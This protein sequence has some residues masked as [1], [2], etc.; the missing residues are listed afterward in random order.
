MW[1]TNMRAKKLLS[2]VLAF[3]MVLSLLPVSALAANYSDAEGHWAEAAINRWSDYGIVTGDE[4]GFRPNDNMT[5]AEAAKV[6]CELFGLT[7][8]AGAASFTDVPADAWYANYIAK[9]NAAGIMGGVGD[10]Q[11]NPNGTL[12][13]ETFF[14]MFARGLGLKEQSATSGVAA[15]G[16][17][18]ANGYINALTD[19]GYVKGDGT[20]VNALANINRAA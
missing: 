17:S 20:G 6:L 8:T 11:A 14:V 1:Y 12:T 16:D 10:N 13:R 3:V 2:V 18:W 9:A 7:S 4:R 19:K 5:R 15:D